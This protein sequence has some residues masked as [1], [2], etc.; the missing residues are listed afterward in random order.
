MI[1]NY[2]KI[3]T[4][5]NQVAVCESDKV[6]QIQKRQKDKSA[7]FICLDRHLPKQIAIEV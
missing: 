1:Q 6:M 3:S 7:R 5:S 2:W 4:D